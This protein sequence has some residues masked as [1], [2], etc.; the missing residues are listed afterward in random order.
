[1]ENLVIESTNKTPKV[2]FNFS[3]GEFSLI[4]WSTPED[5]RKFYE[6]LLQVLNQYAENPSEK[7]IFNIDLEY[8][9][10]SSSKWLLEVF[11]FLDRLNNNNSVIVNWFYEDEDI[12]ETGHDYNSLVNVP[13]N[14][15][16]KKD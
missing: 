6:P 8:Y 16:E 11:Y 15:I 14:F 5:S 4:G 3:D 13:F 9:N 2:I 10:T 1:M 12:L 7:T